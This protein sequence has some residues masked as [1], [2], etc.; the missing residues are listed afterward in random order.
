M[1]APRADAELSS[2]FRK[3]EPDRK[4]PADDPD[5]RHNLQRVDPVA[6]RT[7]RRHRNQPQ[8]LV[9]PEG[10]GAD[11]SPTSRLSGPE[12]PLASAHGR[13]LNPGIGSRVKWA[14]PPGR[15]SLGYLGGG[16]G[17]RTRVRRRWT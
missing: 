5:G 10:V 9:V 2:Q 15:I 6:V 12:E 7:P 17:S 1:A 13:I 8:A 3:S 16:G 14:S 4:R 11:S